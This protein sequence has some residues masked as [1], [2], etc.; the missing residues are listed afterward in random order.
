MAMLKEIAAKDGLVTLQTRC[1]MCS[2]EHQFTVPAHPFSRWQKGGRNIVQELP[3]LSAID[4]EKLISGMCEP[5]Q[6]S[7][8]E[9]DIDETLEEAS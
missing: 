5:C 8:F 4:R 9:G 7:F 6:Q 1:F 3:M 2:L